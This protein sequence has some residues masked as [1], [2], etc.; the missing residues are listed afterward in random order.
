M[1]A[2]D[3]DWLK[4]GEGRRPQPVW[5]FATEAPLAALQLARETG[6]VL[7]ADEVG[8]LYH[9]D[10]RGKLINVTHG[11]SPVRALAWSDT[12][13][14]GLALIGEQKLYWFDRQLTS[15]GSIELDEPILAVACEAHGRYSAIS[16]G[17]NANV[18]YDS[19]RKGVRRFMSTQPL[20]WLEFLIHTPALVAVAEYGLL[21]CHDFSGETVWQ[22]QLFANVGDMALA[23][24]GQT[25]LLA[26][27]MHGIQCHNA[28]GAQVGSYQVGGTVCKVSTSFDASRIAAATQERHFYY[29]DSDGDVIW[30]AT[31]P[32]EVCRLVCDP[33]G[34]GVICGFQSGRILRIDWTRPGA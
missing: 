17:S 24:D 4:R 18:I 2:E 21:C 32:D 28:R 15:Q 16:L 13:N 23:G 6:E 11:P 31:L 26:C 34:N 19:N 25:I 8:G 12:G 27:F 22:Q 30:Q 10:R 3:A 29:I 9:F 7:A 33:L 20:A 5:S 14:G 1:T